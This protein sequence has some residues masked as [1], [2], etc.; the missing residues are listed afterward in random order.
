M[1]NE[2]PQN[3]RDPWLDLGVPYRICERDLDLDP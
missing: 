2:K 1:L 3:R